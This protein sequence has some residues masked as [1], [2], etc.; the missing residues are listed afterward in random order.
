MQL[1]IPATIDASSV[2]G[3]HFPVNAETFGKSLKILDVESGTQIGSAS[4][5][6]S[7]VLFHLQERA[8]VSFTATII[9]PETRRQSQYVRATLRLIVFGFMSEKQTVA[10]TLSDG[11][12]YLQHPSLSECGSQVPYFNPQYLVR[13]EGSM[14][15]LED[16]VITSR[17]RSGG[18]TRDAL[19]EV[20]KNQ[21]LQ[22]FESAQD[23][24]AAFGVR[25]S[26]RLRT[27]LKEFVVPFYLP[28][29]PLR[30][31]QLTKYHISHQISA[32]AMMIEKECGNFDDA[33][34]PSLWEPTE[35][36]LGVK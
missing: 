5:S 26:S 15:K 10:K 30:D 16:L 22:I 8:K 2:D 20:E 13:P 36:P 34:F 18:G 21:M 29:S 24:D 1:E 7:S 28:S 23:P 3:S 9:L 6:M 27:A 25:P 19:T 35:N 4:M 17:S 32:L 31:S 14:P 33:K 11:D 12:L